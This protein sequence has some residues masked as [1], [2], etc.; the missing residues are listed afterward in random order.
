MNE[1]ILI[2]IKKLVGIAEEDPSFDPDM[3]M[4]INSIFIVLWQMGVGPVRPFKITGP[5]ETWSDFQEDLSEIEMIKTYMGLRVSQIF[6]PNQSNAV[7][8]SQKNLINEL[9]WR[10]YTAAESDII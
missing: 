5:D 3:I 10:L 9:E 1:S 6:D 8:E 7:N 2:S 4:H